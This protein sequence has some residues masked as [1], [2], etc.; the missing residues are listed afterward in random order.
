MSELIKKTTPRVL[1]KEDQATDVVLSFEDWRALGIKTD[2]ANLLVSGSKQSASLDTSNTVRPGS[3]LVSDKTRWVV[4]EQLSI[5]IHEEPVKPEK[6]KTPSGSYGTS[7]FTDERVEKEFISEPL[8]DDPSLTELVE[9][10]GPAEVARSYFDYF[11]QSE[12]QKKNR[13]DKY[14]KLAPRPRDILL[15]GPPGTGKTHFAAAVRK[16]CNQND[17]KFLTVR[18]GSLKDSYVG[19]SEK[20]FNAIFD[21]AFAHTPC[22]IFF[23]EAEDLLYRP[24]VNR[25]GGGAVQRD[26]VNVY[27]TRIGGI[28]SN[29]D[30]MPLL[31]AA[32]NT[33]PSQL[34]GAALR[35]YKAKFFVD[36]P[37]KTGRLGI[38]NG[39]FKDHYGYDGINRETL[40]ESTQGL[41]GSEIVTEI[42]SYINDLMRQGR[43]TDEEEKVD[44]RIL[45]DRLTNLQKKDPEERKRFCDEAE[46]AQFL[47][48]SGQTWAIHKSEM[49]L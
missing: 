15:Y 13:R 37:G 4:N 19:N 16:E 43:S 35:R 45:N 48:A 8:D 21:Y 30:A 10:D 2:T 46:K 25:D 3:V 26:L 27:L 44:E 41:S 33:L 31:I 12:E 32:T 38:I 23:D 47:P 20:I 17:I 24:P 9:C 36:F 18:V 28:D 14:G 40:A 5:S 49:S 6:G 7:E 11:S 34:D 29:P 39:L 22:V 1:R 42:E